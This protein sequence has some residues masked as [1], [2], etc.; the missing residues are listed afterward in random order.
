MK[1]SWPISSILTL[2]LVA[3]AMSLDGWENLSVEVTMTII[4]TFSLL[5][6]KL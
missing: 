5:Y 6:L 1:V 2:K 4:A 3:M